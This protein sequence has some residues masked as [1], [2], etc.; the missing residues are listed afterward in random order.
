[1]LATRILIA[2]TLLGIAMA[3]S[4]PIQ[5]APPIL[6]RANPFVPFFKG[7]FNAPAVSKPKHNLL[8]LR[9]ACRKT[10]AHLRNHLPH[11]RTTLIPSATKAT[12]LDLDSIESSLRQLLTASTIGSWANGRDQ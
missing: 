3:I 10:M 7:K 11:A 1:M 6:Q 4:L 9:I 5:P 2:F 8:G 12:A